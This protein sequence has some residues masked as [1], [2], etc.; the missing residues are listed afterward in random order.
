MFSQVAWSFTGMRA[1]CTLERSF[2]AVWLQVLGQATTF[3]KTFATY[4]TRIWFIPCVNP[5][6]PLKVI[7]SVKWLFT[8]VTFERFSIMVNFHM[9]LQSVTVGK[10]FV[11]LVTVEG[12][13]SCVMQGS[14]YHI[15]S[16][17]FFYKANLKPLKHGENVSKLI[18]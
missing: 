14:T 9:T 15:I 11:T 16:Y 12:G 2:S 1:L 17:P 13:L 4:L 5:G 3:S 18:N 8:I 10:W 6:M 7:F